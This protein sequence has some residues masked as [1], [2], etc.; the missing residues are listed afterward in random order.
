[1]GRL[2]LELYSE[3]EEESKVLKLPV[4]CARM[5]NRPPAND[6]G[7]IILLL[8]ISIGISCMCLCIKHIREV[9]LL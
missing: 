9:A 3:L 1:M 5:S 8:L 2:S 6:R 7:A 4:G